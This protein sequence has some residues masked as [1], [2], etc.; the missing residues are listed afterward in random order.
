M[1]YRQLGRAGVRVAPLCLGVMNLGGPTSEEDGVRM[2]H[3]ALDAGINFIDT[4]NVYQGGRSEEIT[5]VAL[6]GRRDDVVLATKVFNPMGA[7]PND[8]GNSRVGIIRELDN[9]LRRLQ[10]DYV[11]LYQLHRFDDTTPIEETLEALT[12]VVRQ[13]KVRYVGISTFPAW[14]IAQAQ[15]VAKE[16]GFVRIATEQPPY[17]LLER[18]VE[19]ELVPACQEYGMGI[20]PWS[21]LAGGLLSDRFQGGQRPAGARAT[22]GFT[23]D[24][25]HWQKAHAAIDKLAAL[26][27][28]SGT[29]LSRFALA[30]LRDA[31]G[32]TAPI[33]GPRTAEQMGDAIASLDV[34]VDGDQRQAV[35]EIVPPGTSLWLKAAVQDWVAQARS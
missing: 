28:E 14:R 9:S 34:T 19:R 11:D 20:I 24:A 25:P 29:T 18:E 13:G 35:D 10:T 1:D 6:Q 33:I 5:G 7:G 15:H 30:W 2:I 17:N 3:E 22:E 23:L 32:V 12:D 8:R 27:A 31:P 4:A 21:P 16:Q 26:A